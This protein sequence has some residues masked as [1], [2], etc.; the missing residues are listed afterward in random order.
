MDLFSC[1]L[2][3]GSGLREAEEVHLRHQESAHTSYCPA[4]VGGY[5][6]GERSP[7]LL[8]SAHH[9]SFVMDC[10]LSQDLEAYIHL[11]TSPGKLG[12]PRREHRLA[13]EHHS[14]ASRH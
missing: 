2:G 10:F 14:W 11:Q 3:P 4:W 13:G 5:S 12:D 7:S 1:P 8:L 6:P 9:V